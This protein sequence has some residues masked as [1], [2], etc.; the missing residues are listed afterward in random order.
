MISKDT[1]RQIARLAKLEFS[2]EEMDGF[3]TEFGKIVAYV[4]ELKEIPSGKSPG[5]DVRS[6]GRAEIGDDHS[7]DWD[8]RDEALENA[9]ERRDSLFAVP[10]VV[11]KGDADGSP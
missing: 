1:V 8:G 9:P 7:E 3:L 10:R 6:A 4:D 5:D 2:D 11:D